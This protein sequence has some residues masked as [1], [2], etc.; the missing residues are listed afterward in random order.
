MKRAASQAALKEIG[1]NN[2]PTVATC[3]VKGNHKS[4]AGT[5]T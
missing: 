2:T 1:E 5:A 4:V 3:R